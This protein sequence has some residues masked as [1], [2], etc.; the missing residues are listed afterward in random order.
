LL[1]TTVTPEAFVT[2]R[3]PASV[4]VTRNA[5]VLEVPVPASITFFVVLETANVVAGPWKVTVF[6]PITS[7][8]AVVTVSVAVPAVPVDHTFTTVAESATPTGT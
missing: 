8:L 1:E 2:P 4:I 5:A 6:V 3:P 7:P